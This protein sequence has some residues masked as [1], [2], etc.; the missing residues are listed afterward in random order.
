MEKVLGIGGSPRKGGNSD[1]LLQHFLTGARA[2]GA[3]TEEIQLRDYHV[4]PCI[5]CE[6]CK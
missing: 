2:A 3:A 4:Q 1:I 5:G 6:K